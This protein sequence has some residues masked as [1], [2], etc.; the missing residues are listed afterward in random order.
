MACISLY[1]FRFSKIDYVAGSASSDYLSGIICKF[2]R[3]YWN[4]CFLKILDLFRNTSFM[5]RH[6]LPDKGKDDSEIKRQP[7]YRPPSGAK[8]K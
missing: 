5:G 3:R 4:T 2:M 8:P 1:L 7:F 6:E